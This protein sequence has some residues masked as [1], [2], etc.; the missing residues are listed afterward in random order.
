MN[1]PSF[2]L[3]EERI[4]RISPLSLFRPRDFFMRMEHDMP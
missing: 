4:S 1:A 3:V 2:F